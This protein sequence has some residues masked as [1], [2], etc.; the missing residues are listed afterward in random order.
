MAPDSDTSRNGM[1]ALRTRRRECGAADCTAVVEISWTEEDAVDHYH[2]AISDYASRATSRVAGEAR[3]SSRRRTA[4]SSSKSRKSLSD[5]LGV[6]LA[7]ASKKARQ[8]VEH[9]AAV[10]RFHARGGVVNM[11]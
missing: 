11:I 1:D 2:R 8:G 10:E 9:S 5:P 6:R 3:E 4:S 7:A